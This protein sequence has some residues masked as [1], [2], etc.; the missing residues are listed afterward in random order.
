MRVGKSPGTEVCL[1]ACVRAPGAPWGGGGGR[2]GWPQVFTLEF[3]PT[4]SSGSS[5]PFYLQGRQGPE[6]VSSFP[7]HRPAQGKAHP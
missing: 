7:A 2:L 3:S 4:V 1:S 6:E 5:L